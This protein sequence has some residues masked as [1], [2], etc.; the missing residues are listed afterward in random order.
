MRLTV[1][2]FYLAALLGANLLAESAMAAPDLA[3]LQSGDMEKLALVDP[4]LPVP[5]ATFL[6]GDGSEVTLAD[7][8]GQVVLLN[9]WATWCA[10]CRE[11]MPT[12]AALEEE[13]GGDDFRVLTIA[14]GRN[15]AP[16]VEEFLTSVDADNLPRLAD[17]RQQLARAMGVLGLPMSIL[18]DRQG[19][20]V[21]RLI[22]GADWNS[23]SARA[24]VQALIDDRG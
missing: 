5:D 12:L 8:A 3:A 15:D 11:E 23:D 10:P 20:E 18:V 19:H 2:G 9:F 21:A 16:A 24:I 17:P 6:A 14:T 22:G 4:P 7:W 13:L 1:T